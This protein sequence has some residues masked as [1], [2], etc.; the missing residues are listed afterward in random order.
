M[1][2]LRKKIHN[3]ARTLG[4]P[5]GS[6]IHRLTTGSWDRGAHNARSAVAPWASNEPPPPPPPVAPLPDEE[7]VQRA[8]RRATRAQLGRSGRAST[9][10]SDSD[11]L[12]P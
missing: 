11:R 7:D 4:D 3:L 6:I 2:K 1:G 12:G 10:L 9:I 8:K 5:G